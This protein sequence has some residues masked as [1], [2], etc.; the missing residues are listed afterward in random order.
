MFSAVKPVNAETQ[1]IYSVKLSYMFE[2]LAPKPYLI[3]GLV[4]VS[5]SYVGEKGDLKTYCAILTG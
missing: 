1:T 2:V 4:I 5:H 3:E